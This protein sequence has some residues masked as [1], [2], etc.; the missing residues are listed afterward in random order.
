MN[1][2]QISK[3]ECFPKLYSNRRNHKIKFKTN[4]EYQNK[5]INWQ[6]LTEQQ[7]PGELS[8]IACGITNQLKALVESM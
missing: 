2:Y 6:K 5:N 7:P 1:T 4:F 8:Y 3:A